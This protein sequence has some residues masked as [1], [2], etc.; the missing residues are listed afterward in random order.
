MRDETRALSSFVTARPVA[1]L[2]VFLAVVVFGW[3]SFGRKEYGHFV[4]FGAEGVG[5]Q[6]K[7]VIA[8]NQRG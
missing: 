3:L 5:G 6:P 4:S 1:I 8:L 2:M 7:S